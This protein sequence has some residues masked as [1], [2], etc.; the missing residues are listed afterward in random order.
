MSGDMFDCHSWG[1]GYLRPP[2][3]G[4]QGCCKASYREQDDPLHGSQPCCEKRAFITQWRC[5]PCH[6][7][8]PSH[9]GHSEG[10]WR[11]EVHWRREGNPLQC[12]CLEKP[13]NS[14]ER[15]RVM[16]LEDEPPRSEGVQ[17][18]PGEERRVITASSRR[19][20]Q[21]GQSGANAGVWLCLVLR[22]KSDAVKSNIA[23]EPGML[24]PWLKANWTWSSR[25]WQEWTL[26][27]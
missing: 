25:R 13:M 21:R 2:V 9:M 23:E 6:A 17:Y 20:K 18:D 27:S 10:F 1:K 16:T 8:P 12:S 15:Q 4:G 7:G 24:G 5:E 22:A 26:T 3:G 19:T 14:T 11:N